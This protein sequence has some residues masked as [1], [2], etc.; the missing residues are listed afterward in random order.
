MT[1][2][3]ID[4]PE[5]ATDATEQQV[6]TTIGNVSYNLY[7]QFNIIESNLFLSCYAR[8]FDPVYFGGL[9]CV[10]GNYI[11]KFDNG[12]PYLLFFIDESGQSYSKIT[13][14]ALNNGVNLYA[15]TR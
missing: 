3:L 11:N 13:F 9:R 1:T 14:E 5:F 2:Y 6:T 7:F 4:L 8:N 15:N 12:L 10:F